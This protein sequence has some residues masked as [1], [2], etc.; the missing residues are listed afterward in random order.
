MRAVCPEKAFTAMYGLERMDYRRSTVAILA[1]GGVV[2]VLEPA[3]PDL[4]FG[5]RSATWLP[6]AGVYLVVGCLLGAPRV[7]GTDRTS[8]RYA[9]LVAVVSALL[10]M[11]L[12]VRDLL[13]ARPELALADVTFVLSRDTVFVPVVVGFMA[14]LGVA[15]R[16]G[17][18]YFALAV[19]VAVIF[20]TIVGEALTGS[21]TG[22]GAAFAVVYYGFWS[23]A[24]AILGLP[25]YIYGWSLRGEVSEIVRR[26]PIPSRLLPE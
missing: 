13:I 8:V 6:V 23:V 25:L 4:P 7:L 22:F 1:L 10:P 26:L 18:R 2:L 16:S 12:R 19:V 15:E 17:E 5:T 11:A 9:I 21:N 3:L 24:G 14:P 20:V